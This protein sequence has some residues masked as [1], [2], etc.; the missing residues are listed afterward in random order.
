VSIL[1]QKESREGSGK[2]SDVDRLTIVVACLGLLFMNRIPENP[3]IRKWG[4]AHLTVDII[5]TLILMVGVLFPIY[6][7]LG[8]FNL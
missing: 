2:V 3:A 1:L 4:F 8:W 6:H 5:F 7:I